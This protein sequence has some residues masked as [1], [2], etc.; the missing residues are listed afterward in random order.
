[1]SSSVRTSSVPRKNSVRSNC[2]SRCRD[3]TMRV[4]PVRGRR[5]IRPRV[6]NA[7]V[8]ARRADRHQ[9]R[10]GVEILPAIDPAVVI[11]VGFAAERTIAVEVR[12]LI[13]PAVAVLIGAQLDQPAGERVVTRRRSA[14]RPRRQR[15][16]RAQRRRS[17]PWQAPPT[18]TRNAHEH[19]FALSVT[20]KTVIDENSL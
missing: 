14:A 3:R 12:P 18:P 1:M 8:P 5:G 16:P 4:S 13:E 6:F 11:R 2:R 9:H 15:I 7:V 10:P 19:S 20:C 17:A